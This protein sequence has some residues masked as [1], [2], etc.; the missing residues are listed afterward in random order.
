[1]TANAI[2]S[3]QKYLF[4]TSFELE[5]EAPK[6]AEDTPQPEF[7]GEDLDRARAEGHA[8]GVE[9]GRAQALQAI[10]S[11]VAQTLESMAQCLPGLQQSLDALRDRQAHAAV[12]VAAALVRKMFP[13]LARDHGLS[14]I[15]AVVKE[16]MARLRDEP[17]IVVRVSDALLDVVEK[18]CGAL[19]K[20]AG[21]EGRIVFL[22][23]DGMA[24]G[25]VRIEWADGGAERDSER[26]W[27]EID[28]IIRRMT[29]NLGKPHGADE[30]VRKTDGSNGAAA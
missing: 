4:D 28:E 6:P 7:F 11:T 13:R 18:R 17:R 23:E 16:A 12:E 29:R 26:S 14:E 30:P 20:T 1:M 5:D 8:E 3:P 24:A 2:K 9:A 25:D 15:D 10:E 22:A 19:A 21:F 27:H